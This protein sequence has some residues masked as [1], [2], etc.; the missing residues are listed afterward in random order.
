[1]GEAALPEVLVVEDEFLIC[2]MIEGLPL[3]IVLAA[4]QMYSRTPQA[5]AQAIGE[6]VDALAVSMRD[7]PPRDPAGYRPVCVRIVERV[8]DGLF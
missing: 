4:A 6:N 5:V 7:L 8:T 2:R 1:M 3:G